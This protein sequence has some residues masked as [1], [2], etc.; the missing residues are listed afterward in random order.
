MMKRARLLLLMCY[1]LFAWSIVLMIMSF[2]RH[3][4]P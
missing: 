4:N 1:I 2:M 3:V